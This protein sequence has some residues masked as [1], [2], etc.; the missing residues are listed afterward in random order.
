M[1]SSHFTEQKETDKAYLIRMARLV[2]LGVEIVERTKYS[3]KI[4]NTP[5]PQTVVEVLAGESAKV[6]FKKVEEIQLKI[7]EVHAEFLTAI[8]AE[9]SKE[10]HFADL[11]QFVAALKKEKN[12]KNALFL[13]G[14]CYFFCGSFL[15]QS[16]TKHPIQIAFEYFQRADKLEHTLAL[17]GLGICYL[18]TENLSAAHEKLKKASDLGFAPAHY[19]LAYHFHLEPEN[20][21]KKGMQLMRAAANQGY[22]SA[23]IYLARAEEDTEKAAKHLTQ[24]AQKGSLAAQEMALQ[25]ASIPAPKKKK[26]KK[27]KSK[28]FKEKVAISGSLP[29]GHTVPKECRVD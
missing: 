7:Q 2:E 8:N 22:P 21:I 12:D 6:D 16:K 20:D 25:F 28:F 5:M 27:T 10:S 1:S 3:L 26:R 4:Q 11:N 13:L 17:F 15:F 9:N 18:A 14:L 24:A 23:H 29:A 19:E